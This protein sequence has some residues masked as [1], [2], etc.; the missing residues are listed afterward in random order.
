MVQAMRKRGLLTDDAAVGV[1]GRWTPTSASGSSLN[2]PERYTPACDRGMSVRPRWRTSHGPD[3]RG[4][5]LSGK[6]VARPSA[7]VGV[8]FCDYSNS[9]NRDTPARRYFPSPGVCGF[10]RPA[11]ATIPIRV[12]RNSTRWRT[13]EMAEPLYKPRGRM[14]EMPWI[15]R[16][17]ALT[18]ARC[19]DA[20][21]AVTVENVDPACRATDTD[22]KHGA[23]GVA[24]V[25]GQM[26]LDAPAY[27][28]RGRHNHGGP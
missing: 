16:T 1:E 7:R 20:H 3:L 2:A 19:V 22:E 27:T 17:S 6:R 4:M 10:R 18:S 26:V 9:T 25:M 21:L 24:D 13:L 11:R 14:P 15:W 28:C 12:V 8:I 5:L 23:V